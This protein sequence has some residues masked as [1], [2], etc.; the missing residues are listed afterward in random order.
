MACNSFTKDFEYNK[1]CRGIAFDTQNDNKLVSIQRIYE[2]K[3]ML[4]F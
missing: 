2:K 4:Q 1:K 3:H